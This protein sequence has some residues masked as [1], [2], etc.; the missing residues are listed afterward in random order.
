MS[1]RSMFMLAGAL[2]LAACQPATTMPAGQPIGDMP[3]DQIIYGL[4]NEITAEG[5]R[6]AFLRGDSAYVLEDGRRL[7]LQ[8]VSL[9]FYD[10]MGK[11]AGELT[12]ISGEYTA[13]SG[14]F[15]A[16]GQVVLITEGERGPRR[17]ETEELHYDPNMQ[18]ISSPVPFVMR[19]AGETSSGQSFRSDT[20]F[21]NVTI[22][23]A[24]GS[25]PSS[26]I[27]F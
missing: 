8:G 19:E 27:R 21:R 23:G 1:I 22:Q 5:V 26:E 3:A 20:Q 6:T 7:E 17:L 24:R 10:E 2:S 16:R 15:I 11:R 25:I 9:E 18:Q 14:L 4:T 12:S 13:G